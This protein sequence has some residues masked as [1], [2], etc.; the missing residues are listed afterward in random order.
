MK[1]FK[2]IFITV[3]SIIIVISLGLFIFY[4]YFYDENKLSIKEKEWIADNKN[5]LIDINIPNKLNIFGYNGAGVFFDF[6]DD[7]EKEY[8]IKFNKVAQDNN[9][10][11]NDLGFYINKDITSRDLPIYKDYYV[12]IGKTS[13]VITSFN[14]LTGSTIGITADTL[15]RVTNSYKNVITYTTL[16]TKEALLDALDTDKVK[17]LIVPKNEYLDL[18]VTKNYK[19]VYHLS[20]LPINYFLHLGS[21]A[22]LNSIILKYY[23]YWIENEYESIYYDYAYNLFVDKLNLTQA[24]TDTLTNKNYT[25]GF[26]SSTP[27]QTLVSSNYGGIT[28]NYLD[29]FS[30]LSDV[31]FTFTK[32]KN[33][34][35]LIKDFNNKKIDL[36]FADTNINADHNKIYTNLNIKY[37]IIAPLDNNLKISNIN[38]LTND[39]VIVIENSKLYSFLNTVPQITLE[40][41]NN[42]KKLLK[43]TRKDRIIAIDANTYDYYV[44]KEINDYNIIFTGFTTENFNFQ[45]VNNN[46]A[47]YKLFNSYINTID[48]NSIINEGLASYKIADKSGN[49]ISIIALNFL[50]IGAI[51][52]GI[53]M[54]FSKSSLRLDTKIRK[55]EKLKF[56]DLLTTLKNRNYLNEKKDVWNN[57][58]IY[59]QGV[60][61][62][63]LNNV[64]YL[65]DTFGHHEGD[66][67]IKAAANIL[68][69]T[70]LDNTE[71]IRTDGN[72]FM[73]YLVG[74]SE[75][76][77]LNYVKKLVKEFKDLPYE[78][79][80][81]I[82]F[83]MIVDDLKLI[84]DAINEAT[85]LMRENKE[86]LEAQNE[87]EI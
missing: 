79:G 30:K 61:I 29:Y 52:M 10:L 16:D 71:I 2:K 4:N 41:V 74:Y 68:I 24:E 23:N 13:D 76:Q 86:N 80:A 47:F 83:S 32:Y 75:K 33:S 18:I 58:T 82:G 42:E 57:N 40:T 26:V 46:D 70:Q 11:E 56:I 84:D 67:Q 51:I 9:I 85:I 81:A 22:T 35:K 59:P 7:L 39:K 12:V 72:E 77:V 3:L 66:K 53:I 36:M 55:K 38:D 62:I 8:L 78:Y 17:Y 25:Y 49:I 15:T 65:N 64:K 43:A 48:N 45:Y 31:E 50:I 19:I 60:I 63:D 1:K 69:K 73:V 21:E 14:D 6:L 87:S 5:N 37:Y 27:Y 28:V 44:N 54:Y 34:E 20:D